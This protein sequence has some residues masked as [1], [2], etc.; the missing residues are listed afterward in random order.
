M[1]NTPQT[2]TRRVATLLALAGLT[3]PLA[4][5]GS[6]NDNPPTTNAGKLPSPATFDADAYKH[7]ECMRRHGVPDFPN[8]QVV[9]TPTQHGIRQALPAGVAESPQFKSAQSACRG[10]MPEP[11]NGGPGTNGSEQRVHTQALLA[12]AHCLRG[13]GVPG[14]PDPGSEGQ[15]SLTQIRAAGVDVQAPSFLTAARACVGVTHGAI[16][17]AQVEQAVHHAAGEGTQQAGE[18]GEGSGGEAAGGGHPEGGG[19]AEGGS[20]QA[21]TASPAPR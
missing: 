14:F 19:E 8:P 3:L 2:T 10:I 9:N 21:E 17:L 18:G 7:A 1:P 12:F 20:G 5:C 11:R 16:T 6:S 13:H 15:L 4:A